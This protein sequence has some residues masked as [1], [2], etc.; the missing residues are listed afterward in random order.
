MQITAIDSLEVCGCIM[1]NKSDI[2]T[3]DRIEI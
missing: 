2:W 1:L 3:I